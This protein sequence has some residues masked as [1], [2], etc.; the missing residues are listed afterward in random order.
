MATN[1][2]RK[3]LGALVKRVIAQALV[4]PVLLSVSVANAW[5]VNWINPSVTIS[6]VADGRCVAGPFANDT[7]TSVSVDWTAFNSDASPGRNIFLV[8]WRD[9]SSGGATTEFFGGA[10]VGQLPTQTTADTVQSSYLIGNLMYFGLSDVWDSGSVWSTS[11]SPALSPDLTAPATGVSG[12]T[13]IDMTTD[14]DCVAIPEINVTGNSR[15]ITDGD[16]S[17]STLDHSFFGTVAHASGTLS[18]TFTIENTG[19]GTLTL[20]A[21]AA[22]LSGTHAADFT[23]TSQP[24]TTVAISGSTDVTVEFDPSALGTRSATLSIANDDADENPYTFAISGTGSG[25]PEINVTGNG[26]NIADGDTTPQAADH[27]DFGS[28]DINDGNI[29]RIFTIENIGDETL[30]LGSNS[31]SLSGPDAAEFSIFS[32]PFSSVS[33]GSSRTFRVRFDPTTAGAKSATLTIA[34]DDADESPYNFSVSGTAAV[35]PEIEVRLDNGILVPNG[36]SHVAYRVDSLSFNEAF[37]ERTYT[38]NNVGS[39]TLAISNVTITGTH[40]AEFSVVTPPAATVVAGGNTTFTLR[41]TQTTSGVRNATINIINNDADEGAFSFD[42]TGFRFSGPDLDMSGQGLDIANG[43][44]TPRPEDDT[45]FGSID[46]TSGFVEKSFTGVNNGD[47]GIGISSISV[48][49]AHASDFSVTTGTE[50]AP[51]TVRFDPSAAG[52]RTATINI[53]SDALV[54]NPFT[55]AIQGTGTVAAPEIAVSS[56]ESGAVADGGTDAQGSEAAAAAK[57]V[58]YTVSNTGTDDLT[59]ATATSSA[60]TNV[61]VNSI[62]VPVATTVT[63][64]NSTTFTVQYTPTIAGAFSFDLAF[65]NND[66]DENPYNITVSGTATGTQE[67]AVSSSESGAV[68]DSGTDAQ[69]S[70]VAGSA[71]TVTYT[72]N[73]TGT[74]DLTLATATSSS[75][76]NVTVN[77]ISAPAS[78]TVAPGNSTTFTVQYTPT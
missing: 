28:I 8:S 52:L 14:P 25:L 62:S 60:L 34:N 11:R 24:A 1:Q 61:T 69:G 33:S 50:V 51:L 29:E 64:G 35:A 36:S 68:A 18:R 31:V 41:F 66:G 55:F 40:A 47:S 20:G 38:I 4:V 45:D 10:P 2:T 70:E 12:Y 58:T 49:G 26:Q 23:V 57:T 3:R 9:S 32:Q 43:D 54:D 42:T 59:M 67:I 76:S 65:T 71:K 21:N 37:G 6:H 19:T 39:D 56:S 78:T 27:T 30:S 5:A 74:D 75:L 48:T 44:T 72:V 16:T 63:P 7:F 13:A 77:S 15:D 17:A 46:V 73:N 22:T 53:A